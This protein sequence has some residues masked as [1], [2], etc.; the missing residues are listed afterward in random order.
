MQVQGAFWLTYDVVFF[1]PSVKLLQGI[2]NAKWSGC[3]H[4]YVCLMQTTA[5]NFFLWGATQYI[6]EKSVVK[7]LRYFGQQVKAFPEMKAIPC[8]ALTQGSLHYNNLANR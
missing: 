3:K 2:N 6:D 4:C 7:V 1:I 5:L 8:L